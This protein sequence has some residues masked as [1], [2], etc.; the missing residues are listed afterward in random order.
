MSKCL[1]G[2]PI[3]RADCWSRI[4]LLL[5]KNSTVTVQKEAEKDISRIHRIQY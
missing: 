3:C 5:I 1:S 2:E 4:H